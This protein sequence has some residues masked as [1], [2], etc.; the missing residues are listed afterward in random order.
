MTEREKE[1]QRQR[2]DNK[3]KQ[4]VNQIA[5]D[6]HTD[7]HALKKKRVSFTTFFR[8]AIAA[9]IGRCMLLRNR[10]FVRVS[11]GPAQIY[12]RD[13]D[14]KY[15]CVF[16]SFFFFMYLSTPKLFEK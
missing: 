2:L 7:E 5:L 6:A 15:F 8:S 9:F 3:N 16:S 12:V 4:E 11:S 1:T 14:S 10:V 13:P